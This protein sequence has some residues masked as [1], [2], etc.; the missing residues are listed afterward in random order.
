MSASDVEFE[1]DVSHYVT[2]EMMYLPTISFKYQSDVLRII[3][4]YSV[5]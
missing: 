4:Y 3:F 5:D 2:H 1:S